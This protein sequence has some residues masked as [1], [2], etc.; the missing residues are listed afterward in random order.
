MPVIGVISMVMIYGTP[1][2]LWVLVMVL[3][4]RG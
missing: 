4:V 1:M 2:V 3:A